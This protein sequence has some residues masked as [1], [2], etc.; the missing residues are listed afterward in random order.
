MNYIMYPE[1]IMNRAARVAG[2]EL[3]P[4]VGE[5]IQNEIATDVAEQ[6]AYDWPEGEGFGS[7]DGTYVVMD[8]INQLIYATGANLRTGFVG[9][10]LTVMEI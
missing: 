5:G 2:Y 8:Y 7:S 9:G 10:Y 1:Q 3:L 6:L 4:E